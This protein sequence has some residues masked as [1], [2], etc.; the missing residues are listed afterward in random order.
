MTSEASVE[1]L[2]MG[3]NPYFTERLRVSSTGVPGT[4]R[5]MF[6]T[7]LSIFDWYVSLRTPFSSLNRSFLMRKV[8]STFNLDLLG[9]PA[10]AL[11]CIGLPLLCAATWPREET[12]LPEGRGVDKEYSAEDCLCVPWRGALTILTDE[13]LAF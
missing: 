8:F 11:R 13:V 5:E 3:P 10:T 6:D 12:R 9:L 7:F 4:G 1:N 2:T